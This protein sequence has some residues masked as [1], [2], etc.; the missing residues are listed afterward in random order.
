MYS[1]Q[2]ITT[3]V[4]IKKICQAEGFRGRDLFWTWTNMT[5]LLKN[6]GLPDPTT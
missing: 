5:R 3:E 6:E 2:I 1:T 4:C